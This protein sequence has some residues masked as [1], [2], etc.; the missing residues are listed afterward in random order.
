M[1]NATKL[2][3]MFQSKQE[4]KISVRGIGNRKIQL[5]FFKNGGTFDGGSTDVMQNSHYLFFLHREEGYVMQS[6][7]VR[8]CCKFKYSDLQD[9]ELSEILQLRSNK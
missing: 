5:Y 9:C 1:I 6:G 2:R 4:F 7:S 8:D 3:F